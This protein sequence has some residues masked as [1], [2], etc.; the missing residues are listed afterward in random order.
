MPGFYKKGAVIDECIQVKDIRSL[1]NP[2][3]GVDK[4]AAQ[5]TIKPCSDSG[6]LSCA[7]DYTQC[8]CNS[9]QFYY[10]ITTNPVENKVCLS[11]K[12]VPGYGISSTSHP[13]TGLTLLEHCSV[14]SCQDCKQNNLECRQCPYGHYYKPPING[15]YEGCYQQDSLPEGWGSRESSLELFDCRVGQYF[16]DSM[17][18]ICHYKALIEIKDISSAKHKDRYLAIYQFRVEKGELSLAQSNP[19]SEGYLDLSGKDLEDFFNYHFEVQTDPKTELTREI[20]Q[21]DQIKFSYPPSTT[22]FNLTFKIKEENLKNTYNSKVLESLPNPVLKFKGKELGTKE[23]QFQIVNKEQSPQYLSSQKGKQKYLSDQEVQ[24]VKLSSKSTAAANLISI[25]LAILLLVGNFD[26]TSL[27]FKVIQLVTI[28][29]KLRFMNVIIKNSFGEFIEYIGELFKVGIIDRDDFHLAS[30]HKNNSFERLELFVIAYRTKT[31]RFIMFCAAVVMRIV[32]GCFMNSLKDIGETEFLKMEKRGRLIKRLIKTSSG[33][34]MMTLLDILFVTGHQLLH[35]KISTIFSRAEYIV[36]YIVSL[37]MFCYS[38]W[39]ILTFIQTKKNNSRINLTKSRPAED[40]NQMRNKQTKNNQRLN[41]I[42]VDHPFN[43]NLDKI[44]NRNADQSDLRP[45]DTPSQRKNKNF[46]QGNYLPDNFRGGRKKREQD[47]LTRLDPRIHKIDMDRTIEK[48]SEDDFMLNF[49]VDGLT[50]ESFNQIPKIYNLMMLL[51]ICAISVSI[52]CLQSSS[53]MQSLLLIII[54]VGFLGFVI[55]YQTSARALKSKVVFWARVME[56]TTLA[57]FGVVCLLYSFQSEPMDFWGRVA[58]YPAFTIFV[59]T[60]I[61][62]YFTLAL[63]VFKAIKEAISSKIYSTRASNTKIS[64]IHSRQGEGNLTKTR[65]NQ[66][67]NK[68]EKELLEY[69][70]THQFILVTTKHK[71]TTIFPQNPLRA[72]RRNKKYEKIMKSR[73]S[74]KVQKPLKRNISK[75]KNPSKAKEKIRQFKDRALRNIPRAE[76]KQQDF[77]R[78]PFK[79]HKKIKRGRRSHRNHSPMFRRSKQK[80]MQHSRLRRDQSDI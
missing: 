32:I 41:Q 33:I 54:E 67:K 15:V 31:D 48:I 68:A 1:T 19:K 29:D 49:L 18:R 53:F 69:W 24:V 43:K 14:S 40:L 5:L 9:G 26:V 2:Q 37:L 80:R 59:A 20:Q 17:N 66:S 38:C 52:L 79:K 12:D 23:I 60:L 27:I 4:A 63:S 7:S 64:K 3:Y 71:N 10:T 34:L 36:S 55:K 56:S 35:Q 44:H 62:E 72:P 47:Q 58:S 42:E 46:P 13:F 75:P 57:L 74:Q 39:I 8:A 25:I 77:E 45:L 78:N 22:N 16:Y 70:T 11:N 76:E 6:C 65:V 73:R 21:G 50:L 51:R 30:V 28:F 61:F